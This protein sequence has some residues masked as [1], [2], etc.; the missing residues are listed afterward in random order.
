LDDEEVCLS[1]K[2]ELIGFRL[3][4]VKLDSTARRPISEDSDETLMELGSNLQL[5]KKDKRHVR[6]FFYSKLTLATLDLRVISESRFKKAEEFTTEEVNSEETMA[7]L[8]NMILSKH[9]DIA[10]TLIENSG[11]TISGFPETIEEFKEQPPSD[12]KSQAKREE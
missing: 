10:K 7:L 1:N 8:T 6:L 4:E 9:L 11:Y 3:K 12:V 5:N 2:P